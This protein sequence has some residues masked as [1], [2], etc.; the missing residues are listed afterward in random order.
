MVVV[1]FFV[2]QC[3]TAKCHDISNVAARASGQQCIESGCGDEREIDETDEQ[4]D[5]CHCGDDGTHAESVQQ[6]STGTM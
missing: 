1:I 5:E 3:I 4:S 2:P 6:H